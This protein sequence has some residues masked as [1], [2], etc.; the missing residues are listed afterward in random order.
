MQC[1]P[2]VRACDLRASRMVRRIRAIAVNAEALGIVTK[3]GQAF[4]LLAV[5]GALTVAT[6]PMRLAPKRTINLVA[7]GT[8]RR[9]RWQAEDRG[10]RISLDLRSVLHFHDLSGSIPDLAVVLSEQAAAIWAGDGTVC[11]SPFFIGDQSSIDPTRM[12][13]HLWGYRER[14]A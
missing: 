10:I 9:P 4:A 7:V 6:T 1:E 2:A 5:Q 14:L 11:G 3:Q 13:A 12:L 8:K